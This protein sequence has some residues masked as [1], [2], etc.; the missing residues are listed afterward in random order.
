LTPREL[1][2]DAA[3]VELDDEPAAELHFP[4]RQLRANINPTT[5]SYNN[6]NQ[7]TKGVPMAKQ[8]TCECGVVL[9]GETDGEVMDGARDHMRA[10]HPDLLEKVSDADLQGWIEEV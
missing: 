2:L 10:D 3:T 1:V 8:I 7:R 6:P 5:A 4:S 9:R